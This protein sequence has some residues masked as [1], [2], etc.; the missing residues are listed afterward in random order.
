MPRVFRRLSGFALA[1]A[2]LYLVGANLFLNSPLGAW[3]VNRQPE[4]F[5]LAWSWG[6]SAWPGHV[7][8]WN[9]EAKGHVRHVQWSVRS[10]HASGRIALLPLLTRELRLPWIDAD[11]VSATIDRVEQ[12]MPPPP[13]RDGG[14]LLRFER[15]ATD[16]PRRLRFGAF[17][18][19]L[20]GSAHVG[21]TKQ[22]RGGP[23][24]ILPSATALTDL[25]I[26]AGDQVLLRDGQ[27]DGTFAIA[28]HR[29]EEA[30]GIARLDFA[31]AD[32]HLRGRTPAL[33]VDLDEGKPWHGAVVDDAEG[34]R[35]D[36]KL[37]L[38]RGV[39]APDGVVDLRL[40]LRAMRDGARFDDTAMLRIGVVDSALH[41]DLALP[42]PP[43]DSGRIQ[44]RFEIAATRLRDLVAIEEVL[45]RTSGTLD[46]D[47]RFT[48]LGWLTPLLVK[49]P[50]LELEGAGRVVAA[51]ELAHGRLEPGSRASVPEVD[52]VATVAGH[53]FS[54]G[55]RAEG[56]LVEGD[57]GPR[58]TVA[59][60]LA[61]YDVVDVEAPG[62]R[63]VQ[64]KDLRID[65]DAAGDLT[66]FR[67]SAKA[68]LRFTDAGVPD[69]RPLNAWLPAAAI[70][71]V[72]GN[73]RVGADL[74]LD[75][76][77]RVARGR[78][79]LAGRAM[80][81]RFGTTRLAGDFDLDARI[82]GSDLKTGRFDLGGSSLK[83]RNLSLPDDERAA[84]RRW[85]I[86][87]AT[88][89]ARI[90]AKRPF[91]LDG[92]AR[93]GMQD[94]GLLL[95]LYARHRDYPRWVFGLLDAGRA[96]ARGRLRF[97]ARGLL[98]DDVEA[99]NDRFEVKAR[100]QVDG[101]KPKGDLLLVWR[102][103]ALGV[104]L[105]QGRHEFHVLGARDWYAA[106]PALLA[107]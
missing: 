104:E 8:L 37:R 95:A 64:G 19:E 47:W 3:T 88:E 15:I 13:A 91:A 49:A 9:V 101:A 11:E 92:D 43:G 36:A 46:I 73:A 96:E 24:E 22:L 54:G 26:R 79:G 7:M 85:W 82:G 16:T 1:L 61:R 60:V 44:G 35:L 23:L 27:L 77:G 53:R 41:V 4:R 97:D 12:E 71:L 10:G 20:G 103:L 76:E 6:L 59:L 14:W 39:F 42:P 100:M 17:E 84:G 30:A 31:D 32:I 21:F 56:S 89:R 78:V 25:V 38:A 94:L 45:A 55:A 57:A 50:W 86:D 74:E 51:L 2:A 93:V 70:E 107:H 90:D 99:S 75:A 67:E 87:L 68:R 81:A 5:Q 63:L 29:R 52:L 48:S 65:L 58:A 34:G 83:L 80:K 105:D 62:V 28:R 33:A 72:G 18:A 98:V 66:D 106:Q 40:P 102:K 69:L